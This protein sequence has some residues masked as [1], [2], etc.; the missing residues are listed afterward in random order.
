[1]ARSFISSTVGRQVWL[2]QP[3]VGL[4]IPLIIEQQKTTEILKKGMRLCSKNYI[5]MIK[6]LISVSNHSREAGALK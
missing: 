5:I 2:L 1:V 3:P 4:C 6:N